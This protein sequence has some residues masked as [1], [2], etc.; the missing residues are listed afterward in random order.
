MNNNNKYDALRQFVL[1]NFETTTNINDRLHTRD[2][3]KIVHDNKLLSYSVC[4]IAKVFKSMNLGEHRSRCNIKRKVQTGYY[5]LIHK[6]G[7]K[8]EISY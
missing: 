7:Y 5:F 8:E 3:V 4:K 6:K 1:E 2:I